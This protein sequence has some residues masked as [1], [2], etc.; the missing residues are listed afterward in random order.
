MGGAT[1]PPR[2]NGDRT[3]AWTGLSNAQARLPTP[4]HLAFSKGF[5]IGTM[6]GAMTDFQTA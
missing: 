2:R 5:S 1:H 6:T 3:P 4:A